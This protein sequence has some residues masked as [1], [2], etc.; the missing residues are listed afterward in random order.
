MSWIHVGSDDNRINRMIEL[1]NHFWDNPRFNEKTNPYREWM[2]I[3]FHQKLLGCHYCP[4]FVCADPDLF[5]TKKGSNAAISKSVSH[6]K[7]IYLSSV[8]ICNGNFR[9]CKTISRSWIFTHSFARK[10]DRFK[11][12]NGKFQSTY[13]VGLIYY[14]T[15]FSLFIVLKFFDT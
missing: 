11:F 13:N 5:G 2:S 14:L 15:F 4:S 3:N 8:Q 9:F 6:I 12:W 1:G 7:F 10:I